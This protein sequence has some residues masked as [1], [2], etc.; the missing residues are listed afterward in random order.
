MYFCFFLYSEYDDESKESCGDNCISHQESQRKPTN[1]RLEVNP[2]KSLLFLRDTK[3]DQSISNPSQSKPTICRLPESDVFAR[4]NAFKQFMTG[5]NAQAPSS[6]HNTV[7][8]VPDSD[9][10]SSDS[11]GSESESS[12]DEEEEGESAEEPHVEMKLA[13]VPD[14]SYESE[15]SEDDAE[16]ITEDNMK[17]PDE[18]LFNSEKPSITELN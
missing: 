8:F 5:P 17:L 10:S 7:S 12:S 14:D 6:L 15:M 4:M 1:M 11:S 16:E 18:I 3:P 9:S 13:I 2:M